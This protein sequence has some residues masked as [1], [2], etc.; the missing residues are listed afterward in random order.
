MQ[1]DRVEAITA[2]DPSGLV[3]YLDL[4]PELPVIVSDGADI[5][6]SVEEHG[7]PKPEDSCASPLSQRDVG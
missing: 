2:E 7:S 1:A 6:D 5:L 4:Q 3:A